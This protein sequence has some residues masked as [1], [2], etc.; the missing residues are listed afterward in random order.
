MYRR[1]YH[2]WLRQDLP[3]W[4]AR[5]WVTEKGADAILAETDPGS[6]RERL[7]AILGVLGAVLLGFAAMTFVAANWQEMGKLVRLALLL[8]AMWLAFGG[9]WWFHRKE[10]PA[11]SEASSLLGAALFGVNIMLISQMY[12][13][14]GRGPEA[15]MMWATGALLV[16]ALLESR[17]ALA[18][19]FALITLW[20]GWESL[21]FNH[22]FHWAF[23][24]VWGIATALAWWQGGQLSRH[25]AVLSLFFWAAVN[26]TG[27]VPQLGWPAAAPWA[28]LSLFA[29]AV[30]ALALGFGQMSVSS[31]QAKPFAPPFSLALLR[32]GFAGLFAAAFLFQAVPEPLARHVREMAFPASPVWLGFVLFGAVVLV[33]G[34]GRAWQRGAVRKVSAVVIATAGLLPP[35]LAT[36][37]AFLAPDT[38]LLA[39]SLVKNWVFGGL[40]LAFTIWTVAYGQQ[41]HDR[42][43]FSLALIAF[44]VEIIHIYMRLFGS[45]LETSLF[46]FLGGV[47]LAVLA[48]LVARWQKRFLA[49]ESDT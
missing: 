18:L 15:V 32:Y 21:G 7:P 14:A 31:E 16:A 48:L 47:V 1:L 28:L 33:F 46:F 8:T 25:L 19:A 22:P 49:G 13:L 12:H 38:F 41:R 45:F 42:T 23:L 27:L 17:A 29:A 6:A 20:S 10:W 37:M 44:S 26:L 24:P 34:L 43:L 5:G 39:L 3:R 30:I 11:F 40:Y 4:Q 9:A 35:I 2:H 36:A